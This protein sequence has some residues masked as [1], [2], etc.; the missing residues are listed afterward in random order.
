MSDEIFSVVGRA[1][2]TSMLEALQLS[3]KAFNQGKEIMVFME[4]WN[5]NDNFLK[6]DMVLKLQGLEVILKS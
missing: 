6:E 3:G 1:C 4:E 2:T 5:K